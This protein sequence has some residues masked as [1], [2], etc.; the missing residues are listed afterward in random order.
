MDKGKGVH[1]W[2]WGICIYK[3]G[4]VVHTFIQVVCSSYLYVVY[5]F[6]RDLEKMD[7]SRATKY[8]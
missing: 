7:V 1:G 6:S 2:D 5:G 3:V 8:S 4:V